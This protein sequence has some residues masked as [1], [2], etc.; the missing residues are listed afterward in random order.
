MQGCPPCGLCPPLYG[1]PHTPN[2]AIVRRD[3]SPLGGGGGN[4]SSMDNCPF[5]PPPH[6][7][8][9]RFSPREMGMGNGNW[10]IATGN[11][12]LGFLYGKC[13]AVDGCAAASPI[14]GDTWEMGIGNG[15]QRETTGD[16]L[17]GGKQRVNNGKQR[18]ITSRAANTTGNNGK[19]RETTGKKAKRER[20]KRNRE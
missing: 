3:A 5:P 4:Q 20:K 17:E 14:S 12:E 2:K 18:E 19:Q 1:A 13:V 16:Y 15:K 7:W 6:C 8:S 9:P 11:W 10:E